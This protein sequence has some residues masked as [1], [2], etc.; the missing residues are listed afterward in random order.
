MVIISAGT[1][2][3]VAPLVRGYTSRQ[4][5]L[6]L[7]EAGLSLGG[8][9]YARDDSLPPG[10]IIS[11]IPTGGGSVPMGTIVNLLVN[12][13]DEFG[14]VTVPILVGEN[15]KK[16]EAILEERGLVLG[17]VDREADAYLL[18]GTVVRQS[19]PAGEQVRRGTAIDL[20][21]TTEDR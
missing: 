15:I 14:L 2:M 3:T 5:Q 4:A 10:V 13:A 21:M 9:S 16:A 7:D 12:E 11:S 8:E 20:T 18:P 1:R 6:M 17:A 19:V